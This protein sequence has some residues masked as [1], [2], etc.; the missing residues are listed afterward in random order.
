MGSRTVARAA[1]GT[2]GQLFL[3]QQLLVLREQIAPFEA[4]FLV[5][6]KDLDFS[7]MRDQMRRILVGA[8]LVLPPLPVL[9]DLLWLP[10]PLLYLMLNPAPYLAAWS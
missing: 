1:G 9:M 2:D 5:T 3:I 4:D 7:H 8:S 10:F 6:E